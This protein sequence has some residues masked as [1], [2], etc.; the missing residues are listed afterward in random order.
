MGARR[1]GREIALQVLYQMDATPPIPADEAL[2]LYFAHLSETAEPK[3]RAFAEQLVQGV[4]SHL[5]EIDRTIRQYSQ[6]WR[7]ERMARVDRNILRLASFELLFS[8]EV[9]KEVVLD[10]GI[11][12]AKR[13]GTEESA[14]FINGV[15]DRI[16]RIGRTGQVAKS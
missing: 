2:R 9:P 1:Q 16:G 4:F 3:V 7:L 13:F 5:D 11:E 14:S 12:L 8:T 15:L 10:E 6:N